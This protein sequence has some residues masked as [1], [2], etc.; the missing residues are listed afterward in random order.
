LIESISARF[1]LNKHRRVVILALAF[2]GNE[3]R[4]NGQGYYQPEVSTAYLSHFLLAFFSGLKAIHFVSPFLP[5]SIMDYLRGFRSLC[6]F[7]NNQA[8]YRQLLDRNIGT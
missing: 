3:K 4:D 7:E 5:I 8:L 6:K 2:K 1:G